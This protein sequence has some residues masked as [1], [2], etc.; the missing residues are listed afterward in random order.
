M[1]RI[2]AKEE[3]GKRLMLRTG[4]ERGYTLLETLIIL[5][6]ISLVLSM[7]LPSFSRLLETVEKETEQRKIINL[8]HTARRRA[9]TSGLAQEI[10]IE[11]NVIT[12]RVD[13]L[14]K[15]EYRLESMVTEQQLLGNATISFYPDGS[16]TGAYWPF[17]FNDGSRAYL[18]VD[19][20]SGKCAWRD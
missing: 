5:I 10:V 11:D 4:N 3:Q 7:T 6:I 19:G 14:E 18:E 20:V 15:I 16:S 17:Q 8:L 9:I 13:E 1:V 12:Y 2:T